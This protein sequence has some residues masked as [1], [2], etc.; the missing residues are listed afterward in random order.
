M[1]RFIAALA[2]VFAFTAPAH[3][4]L[5]FC[6][7]TS[8]EVAAI[9]AFDTQE[10]VISK[11]WFK[12]KANECVTVI[13]YPLDQPYYYFYAVSRSLGLEWSGTYRFC[14]SDKDEFEVTGAGSRC[15]ER[16]YRTM[17]F[18]QFKVNDAKKFIF[19]ISAGP[20]PAAIKPP[21]AADAVPPAAPELAPAA[22]AAPATPPAVTPEVAKP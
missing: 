20:N 22:P 8:D 13:K 16:G 12:I 11:G 18:N 9:A 6:N 4:Q 7:K 21:A 1:R 15:E 10:D 19:N 17:S 14:A 2:L 3:A 5:D